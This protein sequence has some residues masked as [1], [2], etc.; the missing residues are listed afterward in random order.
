MDRGESTAE[1]ERVRVLERLGPRPTT[2]EA[3]VVVVTHD[4]VSEEEVGHTFEGLTRQT[5]PEFDVMVVS[6]GRSRD[7]RDLLADVGLCCEFIGL[8]ENYG[9]N[10]ARN[11]A[12][13]RSSDELLIFLDH[14][15]VPAET[16]VG[17]HLRFHDEHDVVAARG[18]VVPKTPSVYNRLAMN[19]DLGEEPF[20]YL[21]DIEGNCSVDRE[22]FLGVGGF[23][24]GLWGHEGIDLTRRF[25]EV[26]SRD[27]IRYT[28]DPVIRHDFAVTLGELLEKKARHQRAREAL[29]AEDP[30]FFDIY[31]R[32]SVPDDAVDRP[33][34]TT[35]ALYLGNKLS[36][37][38]GA[39]LQGYFYGPADRRI[40]SSS[41]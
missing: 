33:F 24:E 13:R 12:A 11:I 4:G 8:A 1:D 40:G 31:D 18:R 30:G 20:P 38:V 37:R 35:A 29:E 23:R 5:T 3:T 27:R 41:P 28:P 6:N 9:A 7:L 2:A 19:Y 39:L 32:Y 21:L 14:D 34:V 25:L 10:V 16:F 15:A 26:T 17:S 22:A 36:D